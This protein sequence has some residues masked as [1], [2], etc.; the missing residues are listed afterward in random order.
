MTTDNVPKSM[1]PVSEDENTSKIKDIMP[2]VS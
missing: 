1:N 2:F